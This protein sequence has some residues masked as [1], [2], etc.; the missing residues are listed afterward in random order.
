MMVVLWTYI[1]VIIDISI[2]CEMDLYV[3][4]YDGQLLCFNISG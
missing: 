4:S 3:G 1:I 2:D